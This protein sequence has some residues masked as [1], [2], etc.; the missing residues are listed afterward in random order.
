[1]MTR[2]ILR[3]DL[4][5]DYNQKFEK[6]KDNNRYK[7][8]AAT[9]R[10]LIDQFRPGANQ[11]KI[12]VELMAKIEE[13]LKNPMVRTKYGIFNQDDFFVKAILYFFEKIKSE[14]GSLLEWDVRSE[15]TESQRGIAIAFFELQSKNPSGLTSSVLAEFLGK[16]EK[17]LEYD[18]DYLLKSGL[19]EKH[20]SKYY[21]P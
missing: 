2:K 10:A 20:G 21:A 16:E 5:E 11:V 7:T 12:A 14:K 17:D 4:N 3:V 8:D 13:E 6:I 18:L 19:L 9:I 15:L 1:S